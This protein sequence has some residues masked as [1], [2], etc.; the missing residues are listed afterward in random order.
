MTIELNNN[1]DA[2]DSPLKASESSKIKLCSSFSVK[3]ILSKI[4]YFKRIGDLYI[5]CTVNF[6]E[7]EYL[8]NQYTLFPSYY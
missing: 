5:T 3:G 1:S 8:I 4:N 7:S 2:I 6:Y